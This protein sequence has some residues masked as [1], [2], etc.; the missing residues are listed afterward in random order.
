MR[1][2]DV[3]A[4]VLPEQKL[5]LVQALKGAG[6]IVAKLEFQNPAASVNANTAPQAVLE[7]AID[8]LFETA[9]Q[10]RDLIIS[11]LVYH[12]N[13]V[14]VEAQM[15]SSSSLLH[16]VRAMLE[17]RKRHPVFGRTRRARRPMRGR[18]RPGRGPRR[19]RARR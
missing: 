3:F 11:S 15:A 8:E 9:A 12:Y 19:S 14:N 7:R 16:W 18:G 5:L 4:R 6:E 1:R 17:I 10:M 13:N 2:V